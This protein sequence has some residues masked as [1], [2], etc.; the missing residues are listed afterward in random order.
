MKQIIGTLCAVAVLS[1]SASFAQ[2]AAVSG[3]SQGINAPASPLTFTPN[4][5]TGIRSFLSGSVTKN[6]NS[7]N[8]VGPFVRPAAEIGFK[9]PG[10]TGSLSYGA[11]VFGGRGMGGGNA[12]KRDVAEHFYVEHNPV[13]NI[14]VGQGPWKFNAVADLKWHMVNQSTDQGENY[15]EYYISPELARTV[16]DRLTLAVAYTMHRQTNFDGNIG[17]G[18]LAEANKI[19]DATV[20]A[21]KVAAANANLGVNPVQTLHAASLIATVK[22]GAGSSLKSYVRAARKISN[23][24]K[25]E[26]NAYRFQ[27]DFTTSPVKN[28]SLAL[29]YRLNIENK[30]LASE[31]TSYYNMGRVI[32]G[33][34]ITDSLSLNLE[35]TF[36]AAQ[37]TKATSNISYENEQFLGA[38]LTF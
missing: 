19:E 3:S 10:M 25:N 28:L 14:S 18:Q 4:V 12:G 17:A 2:S 5:F 21:S 30:K 1:S 35:N 7:T 33:Y 15:S 23:E 27:A 20:K 37:S 13:A 26:A 8:E 32:A 16:N 11:E 24:S 34:N 6:R 9:Y 22:L 29:R 38:T 31:R 36:K